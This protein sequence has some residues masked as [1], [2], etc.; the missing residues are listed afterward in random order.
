MMVEEVYKAELVP[1]VLKVFKVLVVHRVLK[2]SK[3]E[4]APKVHRVFKVELVL[5]GLLVPVQQ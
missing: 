5:R 3:E 1:K 4:Q 2:V